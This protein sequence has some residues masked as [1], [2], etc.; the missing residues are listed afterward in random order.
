MRILFT[1]LPYPTHLFQ[2]CPLIWAARVEG[3]DVRVASQPILTPTTVGLGL[4]AV[5]VGGGYDFLNAVATLRTGNRF[6]PG[7][8]EALSPEERDRLRDERFVP[9]IE[10]AARMAPDLLAFAG[11]WRPDLIVT[12]PIVLA[13]PLVAAALD[14]PIVRKIWGPDILSGHPLQGQPFDGTERDTWPA[15]LV[16]LFDRHGVEVRN[17]YV[18]HTVDPWPS[19][20]KQIGAPGRLPER[21]IPY[22]GAGAVPEWVLEPPERPR[23]CV[24]CG[25]TNSV[26]GSDPDLLPRTVGALAPLDVEVVVAVNGTDRAKVGPLP[27]NARIAES[28]PLNLLLPSCAAIVNQGGAGSVLTAA[29]LGIPQVL[30]PETGETPMISHTY[31]DGGAAVVL[32]PTAG[33]D[34]I[35]SAVTAAATDEAMREA[36]RRMRAEIAAM[37][38][39]AEVVRTLQE[40]TA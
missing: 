35:A 40:L 32:A 27:G 38:A 25:T 6:Q 11:R 28:L 39:P 3:H 23:V 15:G 31:A 33:A 16:E 14:I 5:E 22:N 9:V 29:S 2:Q 17:D 19:S 10:L 37:P 1:P 18:R 20:L 21:F 36:A 4:P 8:L 24:T 13:A 7:D 34:A 12:D 26:F 30:I